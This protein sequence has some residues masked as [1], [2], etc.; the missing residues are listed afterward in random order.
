[1]FH[2]QYWYSERSMPISV[3]DKNILRKLTHS[4]I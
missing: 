2:S 3:P 1:M 4:Y